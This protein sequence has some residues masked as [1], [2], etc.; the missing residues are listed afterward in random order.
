MRSAALSFLAVLLAGGAA[1]AQPKFRTQEIGRD[2]N[3][4]Y[5]VN[6]AD[7]NR[8][9]KPDVVAINNTQAMWFENPSWKK[10]VVFD[11][12]SDG[13][14]FWKKDNVTFAVEDIDG[15]GTPDMALGAD[16]QPSNTTGGGSLQ[17]LRADRKNPDAPWTLHPLSTEPTIH[18][19]RWADVDGDGK[20]ELVV[21]ALHGRGTKGPAWEGQ[22]LRVLVFR[23]PK[24]PVNDPW[25]VEI[26]D[27][28]LH[29]GHNFYVHREPGAKADSLVVA[30]KEGVTLLARDGKGVWARRKL[31]EGA[32]GEIKLGKAAGLRHF[33]CVEPWHGTSLVL[34]KDP[35]GPM[36]DRP[37]ARE[38]IE[39][40]LTEAHG[41]GWGDFDGDGSD[42]L[43]AGWRKPPIGL[44]LFRRD[45]AGKWQRSPV[46]PDGMATE[47]VVV[48]DLDGNGRP[49]IVAGGRATSNIRIY[50]PD[51]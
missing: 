9:G 29:I 40:K 30:S 13:S 35:G 19:I 14:G 23:K 45:A 15:D 20:R 28:T 49:E 5:A 26:A 25:L 21:K 18:R 46:D 38:V 48:A 12:P 10:H 7:M 51:K 32:P 3:V 42:E 6:V 50:W 11:G 33:A 41:I 2:L 36:G 34:Y 8:D 1:H 4:V 44:A 22:G 47:D 16:W 39:S 17:W 24:S 31:G 37:W 43:V 27:D